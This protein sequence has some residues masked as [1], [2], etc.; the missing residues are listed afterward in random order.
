MDNKTKF[1]TGG[2]VPVT[3]RDS[4]D[5]WASECGREVTRKYNRVRKR[6]LQFLFIASFEAAIIAGLVTLYFKLLNRG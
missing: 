4:Y 2:S 1:K 3:H 6:M 5:F